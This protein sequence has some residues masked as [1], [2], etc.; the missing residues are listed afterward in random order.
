MNINVDWSAFVRLLV[1]LVQCYAADT[2]SVRTQQQEATSEAFVLLAFAAKGW[3]MQ[4][5]CFVTDSD[6]Q[7]QPPVSCH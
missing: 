2:V 7:P 4:A 3:K 6:T 5:V 1:S